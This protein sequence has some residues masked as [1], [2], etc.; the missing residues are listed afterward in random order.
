MARMARCWLLLLL[1]LSA[2]SVGTGRARDGGGSDARL[3]PG[4]DGGPA[5]FRCTPDSP[6]CLGN[7]YYECGSDGRTRTFETQCD[8]ACDPM[9]RCVACRPGER[10]CEGTVSMVCRTDGSGWVSGRDCAE[11][12]S[13]CGGDGY[14]G[15]AC[16]E[17]ERTRSNVGCEYWPTPLANTAELDRNVFDFRVVVAN[18]NDT[19][20]NVR[21]SRAGAEAWSGTVDP[22][23]LREITLPWIDGESFGLGEGTWN[24][25]VT[26]G[27]AYRLT[28]DIPVIASQFNPFEYSAGGAFSYTNDATLLYPTH[29]LTG[30][31]VGVSYPPLSRRTGTEGGNGGGAFD[32]IRY[33]G[34]IAIVGVSPEPTRVEVTARGNV[35]ADAGGR[36]P[37]TAAGGTFAFT[38]QQGEV[39]HVAAAPPPECTPGRPGFVEDRECTTVPIFGTQCDV[40]QTCKEEQH[41]LTGTRI[42][43]DHPVAVFGGHV[44]AYVPT[45]A[46]ACDHLEAM[47]PPIQSWGRAFV[48]APMGDGS[49]NGVNVV[50]VLPA[51]EATTVTISPPQGGVSGGTISPGSF[52]EMEVTSPF[53]V[54]ADRAILV[55]QYLRGQYATMPDSAR[56]DPGLTV[57]VPAEQYREDY[58][59]ILPSSYNPGT[60]GQNHLLIVRPPG[61][62]LT[63]DGAP[64]SASWQTIGGREV[65]VVLLDGGTHAIHG[66]DT[67]GLT[68][69][70]L[71]SFTSY[72]TP[73]GLNLE[74]ITILF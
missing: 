63:L 45:S 27:G 14:C 4:V 5:E 24:S 39:A 35:A 17:A 50:R 57:L 66:A 13:A 40:F 34:Y 21:V 20:A 12:G 58:T 43:A 30:D 16:A 11:W 51:F 37:A 29:T 23:G 9:L 19:P 64:V 28:S 25:I 47:M 18:P 52:L 8:E 60:N 36:F 6:G 33:G 26:A 53:E 38:L 72:A 2:C 62:E 61:L 42:A 74:P 56:G 1:L 55:A 10:R 70:G 73:A 46:Q 44:C 15:D 59:F 22:H 31:Y 3:P 48:S 69:Y 32:S 65:G 7:L 41:D 49:T 71:G 68:A 54:Q 67:F